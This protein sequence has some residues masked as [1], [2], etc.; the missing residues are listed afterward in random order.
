ML[1]AIALFCYSA[2]FAALFAIGYALIAIVLSVA[3]QQIGSMYS[4]HGF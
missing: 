2:S 4:P 1:A 3:G